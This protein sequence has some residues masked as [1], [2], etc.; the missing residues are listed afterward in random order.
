VLTDRGLP[1]AVA[2]IAD[3]ATVPV[4]IAFELPAR[5]PQPVESAAYFVVC[6]AL[7]N[8][9]KHS[10][11]DYAEIRGWLAEN[12]LLV[13]VRDNGA[14]GANASA[15]TGLAGLAD[16]LSVIDGR[17]LISSPPGGPTVRRAEI[18]VPAQQN[19]QPRPRAVRIT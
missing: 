17:L 8:V 6:E 1:A 10:G 19:T 18:P 5:L 13:E 15:G 7:A 11:A 12:R 3:R 9:A 14:G 4:T 2:D 16:R